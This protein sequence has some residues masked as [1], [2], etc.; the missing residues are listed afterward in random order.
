M[1]QAVKNSRCFVAQQPSLITYAD[2]ESLYVAKERHG[3][4]AIDAHLFVSES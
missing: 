3:D 1:S 4:L 2:G